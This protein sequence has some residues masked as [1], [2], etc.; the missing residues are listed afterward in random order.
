[1]D[2]SQLV[3][4]ALKA[5]D[6]GDA[7]PLAKLAPTSIVFGA[8]DSRILSGAT[9]VKVTR[10]FHSE[11]RGHDVV[12]IP[13]AGQFVS[14]VP[15]IEDQKT[16]DL[17]AEGLLDC[18]FSGLGGVL[19][20]GKIVRNSRVNIRAIRKLRG[21]NAEQTKLLQQYILGLAL[22]ALA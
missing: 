3:S 6:K 10:I 21:A 11:I 8:W 1:S 9:G 2:K 16:G 5:Y 15:R 12:E 13:A 17:S 14:S 20:R 19:V 7:T 4:D 22:Y 18:P